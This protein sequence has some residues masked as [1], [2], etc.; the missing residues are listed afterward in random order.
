L[1]PNRSALPPLISP[2]QRRFGLS[3]S[4]EKASITECSCITGRAS[5]PVQLEADDPDLVGYQLLAP[6]V[7]AMPRQTC[8]PVCVGRHSDPECF[9]ALGHALEDCRCPGKTGHHVTSLP[10]KGGT[11][12]GTI[13]PQISPSFS[14]RTIS[15]GVHPL[16]QWQVRR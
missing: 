5:R 11:D 13:H 9:H 1:P 15:R 7:D 3:R 16:S 4:S 12:V 14:S 6:G 10:V 2:K 8:H